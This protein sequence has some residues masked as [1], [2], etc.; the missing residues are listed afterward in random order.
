MWV[1]QSL[2]ALTGFMMLTWRMDVGFAILSCSMCSTIGHSLF[3][4]T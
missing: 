2:R 3:L 1:L 4:R